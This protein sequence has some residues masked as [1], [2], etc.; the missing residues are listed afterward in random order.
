MK[1]T[2]KL[3]LVALAAM[4]SLNVNGQKLVILHTNDSHSQIEPIR[5]GSNE[6]RGGVD[7]RLQY[8]DSV[9]AVYGKNKV[10]LL[11]A[12]DY[13]QGS[14]YYVL[15]KGDIELA[16]MN[17]LGYEAAAIRNHEF[18]SGQEVLARHLKD[19]KFTSLCCNYD[20]SETP[21]K[22]LIKPYTI[23]R[24]NG[25]K[26]GIVG[27]TSY[28]E[29]NVLFDNMK[30]MKRLDT[31]VEVNRWARYLKRDKHCDLVIFL[32]HLGYSGG[33]YD[34][35]SDHIMA[36]ESVDIDVIVGGHSH[37]FIEKPATVQNKLGK[38]VIIVQAG[39]KGVEVGMLKVF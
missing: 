10:L 28:L 33:S 38:D 15:G 35:P 5:T 18:D 20:F 1:N 11:D 36:A 19:A 29:S 8:I 2:R 9:R 23:I 37:T 3:L 17:E 31:V 26:I 21:L 39:C 16:L 32:S 12:G 27:A 6:G 22:D 7:R 14:P 30:N 25:L 4:L 13:N 24:K 34:V